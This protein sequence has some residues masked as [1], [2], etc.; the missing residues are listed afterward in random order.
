MIGH[1]RGIL[2]SASGAPSK[3]QN[4]NLQTH[5]T[6]LT[7]HRQV[8]VQQQNRKTIHPLRRQIQLQQGPPR[9][10]R[11]SIVQSEGLFLNTNTIEEFRAIDPQLK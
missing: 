5:L 2:S 8:Q 3:K 11:T 7:T 9:H 10:V 6:P 4:R 1:L